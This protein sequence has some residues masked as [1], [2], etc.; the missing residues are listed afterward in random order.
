MYCKRPLIHF[1]VGKR[2]PSL[3][4]SIFWSFCD[5][6]ASILH[7]ALHLFVVPLGLIVIILCLFVVNL[8]GYVYG[9][10]S[11]VNLDPWPLGQLGLCLVRRFSNPSMKIRNAM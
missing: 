4:E 11:F 5:C 7:F 3:K 6:F 9:F 8:G 2:Q 10:G 1:T